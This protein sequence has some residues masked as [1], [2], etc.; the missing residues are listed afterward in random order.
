MFAI[1]NKCGR[2]IL[3][4][5]VFLADYQMWYRK[6]LS[7]SPKWGSFFS[8][9]VDKNTRVYYTDKG[10]PTKEVGIKRGV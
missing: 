9:N 4:V 8:V 2:F 1:S 5:L 3:L 7:C 10:K 6:S